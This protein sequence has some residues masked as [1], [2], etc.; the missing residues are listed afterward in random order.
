MNVRKHQPPEGGLNKSFQFESGNG[1]AQ[2]SPERVL[3]QRVVPAGVLHHAGRV[4]LVQRQVVDETPG[5]V[6]VGKQYR[7]AKVLA[8]GFPRGHATLHEGRALRLGRVNWKRFEF[9]FVH[10]D[11]V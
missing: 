10:M 9:F 1:R 4:L 5:R 2:N 11:L 7:E 6:Q 3:E 8:D